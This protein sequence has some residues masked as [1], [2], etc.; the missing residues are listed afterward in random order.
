MSYALSGAREMY[1]HSEA[2]IMNDSVFSAYSVRGTMEFI[3]HLYAATRPVVSF[4]SCVFRLTA[5]QHA[6]TRSWDQ[7]ENPSHKDFPRFRVCLWLAN[8]TIRRKLGERGI[9]YVLRRK[10][11]E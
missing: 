8:T 11:N 4:I 6:R 7:F 3:A 1:V 2:Y 9:G 10:G 5:A